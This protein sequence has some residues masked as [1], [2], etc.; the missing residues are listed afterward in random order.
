MATKEMRPTTR[1]ELLSELAAN[2]A[3]TYQLLPGES[4]EIVCQHHGYCNFQVLYDYEAME[5]SCS[6]EHLC[7]PNLALGKKIYFLKKFIENVRW[8]NRMRGYMR[9]AN[10]YVDGVVLLRCCFCAWSMHLRRD[11]QHWKIAR[12]NTDHTCTPAD[13]SLLF[14]SYMAKQASSY[15]LSYLKTTFSITLLQYM[16]RSGYLLSADCSCLYQSAA[17]VPCERRYW[18]RPDYTAESIGQH[19]CRQ[20]WRERFGEQK[21]K[22]QLEP[23]R[24]P[25]RKRVLLIEEPGHPD[26]VE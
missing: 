3:Y 11:G 21:P 15:C 4:Q 19:T 7:P 10:D 20:A 12:A 2:S 5:Y 9:M 13:H 1:E 8:V 23:K 24:R 25:P 6:G 17:G 22:E 16:S 18:L 14:D 26:A